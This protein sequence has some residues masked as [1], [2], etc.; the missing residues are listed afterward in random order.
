MRGAAGKSLGATI[1]NLRS[2]TSDAAGYGLSTTIRYLRGAAGKGLGTTLK[3]LRGAAGISLRTTAKYLR[4]STSG[5]ADNGFFTT[6]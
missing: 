3:Y 2:T 6:I 1:K 4:R 5:A